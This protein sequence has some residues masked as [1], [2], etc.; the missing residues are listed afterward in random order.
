[1]PSDE[2]PRPRRI[3]QSKDYHRP[4]T[5]GNTGK[6]R[7]AYQRKSTCPSWASDLTLRDALIN[8]ALPDPSGAKDSLGRVKKL[9]NAVDGWYFVGVSCN[10]QEER[11][12]CYPEYPPDGKL[13]G[14]LNR[15][16]DRTVESVLN[17]ARSRGRSDGR[18]ANSG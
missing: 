9:W 6:L 8:D 2:G 10:L 12:N 16:A 4:K 1:M 18:D 17:E 5:A 15:R 13:I 7:D 14:D 11:Y 3:V